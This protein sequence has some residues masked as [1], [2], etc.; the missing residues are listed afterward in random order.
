MSIQQLQPADPHN[1]T[2]YKP[3]FQGNKQ[4]ILSIAISLYQKEFWRDSA[5]LKAVIVFL[6]RYLVRLKPTLRPNAL[7]NTV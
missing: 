6:C 4:Q 5:R 2:V 1:V 3:Y 7:P